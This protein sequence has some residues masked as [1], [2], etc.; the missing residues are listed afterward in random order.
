[1]LTTYC[2]CLLAVQWRVLQFK[3]DT[4]TWL[5]YLRWSRHLLVGGVAQW[6]GNRSLVGSAEIARPHNV[7]PD[8]T[9]VQK[10]G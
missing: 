7:A 8:Q 6:L 3:I 9:V 4:P 1:M 10:H 2:C 5:L